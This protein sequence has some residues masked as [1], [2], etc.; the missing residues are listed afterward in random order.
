VIG[1]ERRGLLRFPQ[2]PQ[3][4][5]RSAL[6]TRNKIASTRRPATGNSC[7]PYGGPGTS[8]GVER[9]RLLRFPQFP[10]A[11]RRSARTTRNDLASAR[12]LAIGSFCTPYGGQETPP[13]AERRCLLRF[14]QFPQALR[15]SARTTQ[16][17]LASAPAATGSFCTPYGGQETPPGVSA[18]AASS[19][20]GAAGRS[21][22]RATMMPILPKK[23]VGRHTP[24]ACS[25]PSSNGCAGTLSFPRNSRRRQVPSQE[26]R[27]PGVL[28]P[29]SRAVAPRRRDTR[30]SRCR[31]SPSGPPTRPSGKIWRRRAIPISGPCARRL[32]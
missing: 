11:P 28:L 5:R 22:R 12:P 10:Q 24:Q 29:S 32:A 3:A 7:V 30:P 31:I 6:K 16:N 23:A 1:C 18:D 9:R 15:Q 13:G 19:N 27:R 26:T 21:F 4:L 2:F 25:G 17:D 8:S 14:P 20:A